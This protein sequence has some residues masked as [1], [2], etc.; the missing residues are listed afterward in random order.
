MDQF[1]S[2]NEHNNILVEL[3][4]FIRQNRTE[5]SLVYWHK[6]TNNNY[7]LKDQRINQN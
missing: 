7:L 2:K 5:L 1:Q 6:L 4:F 3:S